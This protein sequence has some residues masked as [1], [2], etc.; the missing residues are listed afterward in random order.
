LCKA[1]KAIDSTLLTEPHTFDDALNYLFRRWNFEEVM[2]NQ[3]SR[4]HKDVI[5]NEF[6]KLSLFEAR[7]TKQVCRKLN[8]FFTTHTFQENYTTLKSYEITK[9]VLDNKLVDLLP[10]NFIDHVHIQ[11]VL[12][13]CNEE[14]PL[15]NELVLIESMKDLLT[16]QTN[17]QSFVDIMN[18]TT[19]YIRKNDIAF[20]TNQHEL[21]FMNE[22]MSNN[23][24]TFDKIADINPFLGNLFVKL[25]TKED[26]PSIEQLLENFHSIKLDYIRDEFESTSNDLIP[27]FYDPNLSNIYGE[28][29]NLDYLDYVGKCQ[30]TFASYAF[31]IDSIKS[32]MSLTRPMII[33]AC[34]E[35]AK[36]ALNDP[37]N[38]SLVNHAVTFMEILSV[39]TRNLRCLLQLEKLK[40]GNEENNCEKFLDKTVKM[41]TNNEDMKNVESLEVFWKVKKFLA[42]KRSYLNAFTNSDDWFKIILLAQYFNYSLH[43]FISVCQDRIKNKTLSDNL[44]RAVSY[45][46]P[47]EQKHSIFSNPSRTNS[48][49][50]DSKETLFKNGQFLDSKHD[51][52][53]ILLKCNETVSRLD[54][55][56]EEFQRIFIKNEHSDDLFYQA[57]HYDWPVLAVLAGTTKLYRYKYCWLTWLILSSNFKW[58]EKFEDIEEASTKVFEHCLR[59]GFLKTL[60]ESFEIFYPEAPM[61]IFTKFL[62]DTANGNFKD[63]E[64]VLKHFIV[65]LSESDYRSKI[66]KEKHRLIPCI[67]R[68]LIIHL[69]HNIK[70]SIQQQE[71]LACVHR[72]EIA[73]FDGKVDFELL[74]NFCKILEHT[75]MEIN[76][77]VFYESETKVSK[78]VERICDKLIS[79]N[80]FEAAIEI[81][82]LMNKSKTEFVFKYWLHL[83]KT[84]NQKQASFD[85]AKYIKYVKMYRLN[86]DVFIKFLKRVIDEMDQCIEKYNLMI[87]MLRNMAKTDA[88]ELNDLEYEIICLYLRLKISGVKDIKAL[89][90][91]YYEN[92]IK[93]ERSLIHNS[94]Y[95]LKAISM[96][97]DLNDSQCLTNDSE[98]QKLDELMN[99]LL[100]INDIVQVLR[101]QAMF[102]YAPEDLKI[103]VYMLSVA[104][105]ITSIYD[106]TKQERQAISNC[107]Q[108][109]TRFNRFAFK[110]FR[111]STSSKFTCIFSI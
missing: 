18:V 12:K 94:L 79:N 28:K 57:K 87:F 59:I 36:L 31:I 81:G 7:E 86:I 42:P 17:L 25:T 6:A 91:L 37:K 40:S 52:F 51:L 15:Y 101:I 92:V 58:N 46:A 5:K 11:N 32:S 1:G 16:K 33:N 110:S 83:R 78:E 54:M 55:P 99:Y 111:Q 9:F 21:R 22:I 69:Q 48:V 27:S 70:F 26:L 47:P 103:L 100:D 89:T 73:K 43:A 82:N 80:Y 29:V 95:E 64:S 10:Q 74:R 93:P 4:R 13:D 19:T 23:L 97:D 71:Y 106:I 66:I 84:D 24:E 67:I 72:S 102:G 88:K 14:Y 44:I 65:Q 45:E 30:G 60:D 98:I 34:E 76:Y 109:S 62:R 63:M 3:I 61:K 105:G 104:E 108:L 90:S 75:S 68:Y 2:M 38:E 107:G 8:R 56:F 20:N 49:T 50:N 53:A 41:T 77:E 35:V 96:I 85:I 39:D